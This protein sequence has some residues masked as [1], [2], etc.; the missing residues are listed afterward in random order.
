ME[1]IVTPGGHKAVLLAIAYHFN[2]KKLCAWPGYEL[3]AVESGTSRATVARAVNELIDQELLEVEL[4]V[5]DRGGNGSNR[6]Y[7]P[8]YNSDSTAP[9]KRSKRPVFEG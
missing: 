6:Y 1:Q 2:E 5:H 8:L 7:L 9:A 3:L 4:F